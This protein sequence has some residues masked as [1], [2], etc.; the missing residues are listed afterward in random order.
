MIEHLNGLELTR[1]SIDWPTFL[2]GLFIFCMTF[3]LDEED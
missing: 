2:A 1:D 3:L